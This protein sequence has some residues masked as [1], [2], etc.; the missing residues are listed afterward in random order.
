MSR[1]NEI[2]IR[3]IPLKS[4]IDHLTSIYE[5]GGV[6]I[7]IVGSSREKRDTI[8]IIVYDENPF[9]IVE[10]EFT[11]EDLNNLINGVN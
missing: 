9:D 8:G 7:D 10:K 6:F 4:F 3:N 5:Q 11:G 1:R 2:C